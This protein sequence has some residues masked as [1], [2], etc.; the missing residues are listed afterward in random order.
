MP[1]LALGRADVRV[2]C[3]YPGI[4]GIVYTQERAHTGTFVR[5]ANFRIAPGTAPILLWSHITSMSGGH[6][7]PPKLLPA[8]TRHWEL[9]RAVMI[10]S[11]SR[12][13]MLTSTLDVSR[14]LPFVFFASC[15][16][17]VLFAC[18]GIEAAVMGGPF[19]GIGASAQQRTYGR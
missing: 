5:S 12:L 1:S 11:P 18:G 6:P 3:V 7:H 8:G 9:I 13:G 14:L 15:S 16:C 4:Q 19:A 17:C 2:T 10:R